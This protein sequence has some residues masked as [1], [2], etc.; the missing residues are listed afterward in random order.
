MRVYLFP[1]VLGNEDYVRTNAN[2]KGLV[3]EKEGIDI[4]IRFGKAQSVLDW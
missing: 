1:D 3:Y 2:D 4:C